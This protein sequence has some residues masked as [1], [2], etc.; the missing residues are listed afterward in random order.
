MNSIVG[1][2]VAPWRQWTP[3]TML[4]EDWEIIPW[5]YNDIAVEL[6]INGWLVVWNIFYDIHIFGIIIPTDFYIFQRGWNHQPEGL[7]EWLWN[8][9]KQLFYYD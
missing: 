8:W 5:P 3:D 1:V 2:V 7:G 9:W 4:W 6:L